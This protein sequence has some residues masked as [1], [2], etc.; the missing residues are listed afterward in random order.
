MVGNDPTNQ[1][2]LVA[3]KIRSGIRHHGTQAFHRECARDQA[4]TQGYASCEDW[5]RA[6]IQRLQLAGERAGK[7]R[8]RIGR[9]TAAAEGA[10]RTIERCGRSCLAPTFPARPSSS[11][12]HSGRSCRAERATWR[13]AITAIRAALPI[14]GCCRI[15]CPATRTLTTRARAMRLRKL[16]GGVS[17]TKAGMTAPQMV[18]AAQTGKL[19][20]ALRGGRKSADALRHAGLR[21][22]QSAIC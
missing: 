6:G 12:W 8:E 18:E 2:P 14:W 11:W 21:P 5:R 7:S 17:P 19:Q 22:R 15:G 20:R 4:G 1:N 13:W 9:A 16:W 10:A 3:W